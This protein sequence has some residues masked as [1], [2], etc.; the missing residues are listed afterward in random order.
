MTT[1]HLTLH[2]HPSPSY[3]TSSRACSTPPIHLHSHSSTT[4]YPP[5]LTS[6]PFPAPPTHVDVHPQYAVGGPVLVQWVP[7]SHFGL[8]V[9]QEVVRKRED[10][11]W[12]TFTSNALYNI[13]KLIQCWSTQCALWSMAWFAVRGYSTHT[14]HTSQHHTHL[15]SWSHLDVMLTSGPVMFPGVGGGC[16]FPAPPP[17]SCCCPLAVVE[18][19]WMLGG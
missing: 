7:T 5:M 4:P 10:Q 15:R 18:A 1:E 16:L 12:I 9:E 17:C 13:Y 8:Q 14:P 19:P 3:C 6:T 2:P 11:Q